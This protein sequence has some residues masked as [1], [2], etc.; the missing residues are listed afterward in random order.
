MWDAYCKYNGK[1]AELLGDRPDL[2]KAVFGQA[3]FFYSSLIRAVLKPA[4]PS[5][6]AVTGTWE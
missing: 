4:A 3:A 6:S 5:L 2:T 1:K